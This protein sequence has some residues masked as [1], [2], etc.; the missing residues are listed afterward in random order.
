MSNEHGPYEMGD[1]VGVLAADDPN[2]VVDEGTIDGEHYDRVEGMWFYDVAASGGRRHNG[3]P[4]TQLEA[5]P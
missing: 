5:Q 4:E 1:V 3:V 2:V